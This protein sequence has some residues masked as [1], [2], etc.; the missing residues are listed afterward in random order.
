MPRTLGK[1][2]FT[3]DVCGK[4]F[5]SKSNLKSHQTVH[6]NRVLHHCAYCGKDFKSG[7]Y[8]KRHVQGHVSKGDAKLE[9][10]SAP[11]VSNTVSGTWSVYCTH[12][13]W[14]N[15]VLWYYIT[16]GGACHSVCV[17][18]IFEQSARSETFNTEASHREA[19]ITALLLVSCGCPCVM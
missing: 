11:E 8:F 1:R 10:D 6:G 13:F 18:L 3:C 17:H 7:N 14:Y 4:K 2:P 12:L 15:T 9:G 16:V 5:V 19:T